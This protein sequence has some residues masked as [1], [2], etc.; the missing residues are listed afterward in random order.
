MPPMSDESG[1]MSDGPRRRDGYELPLLGGSALA[2]QP[3]QLGG[4]LSRR[5]FLKLRGAAMALGGGA[6]TAPPRET[7]VPYAPQPE[8]QIPGKPLFYA[9]AAILGGYG[10]GVLIESHLGRPTKVEGNPDHPA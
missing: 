5:R 9:S 7:I 10:E 2:L 3:S 1:G 4:P 6:C 8:Q